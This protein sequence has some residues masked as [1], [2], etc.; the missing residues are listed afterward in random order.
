MFRKFLFSMVLLAMGFTTSALAQETLTVYDGDA[1]NNYVPI[2]GLYVDSYCKAEIVMNADQLTDM[3]GGTISGLTWYLKNPAAAA[4][5]G[6]VFQIFM[7]EV[8]DATIQSYW[9]LDGAT[10]VYEGALDGTQSE[11]PIEFTT[12]YTSRAVIC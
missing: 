10:V 2:Y 8:P 4:W 12:P 5:T 3:T 11:L 6:A 7:K 1:T 9:G